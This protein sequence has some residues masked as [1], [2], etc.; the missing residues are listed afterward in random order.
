MGNIT[1]NPDSKPAQLCGFNKKIF[2]PTFPQIATILYSAVGAVFVYGII[3]ILVRRARSRALLVADSFAAYSVLLPSYVPILYLGVLSAIVQILV[4]IS[5]AL[6]CDSSYLG[7]RPNL[8]GFNVWNSI[9]Y[10]IYVFSYDVYA[11]IVVIYVSLNSVSKRSLFRAGILGL[12]IAGTSSLIS[13]LGVD[14]VSISPKL[15]RSFDFEMQIASSVLHVLLML[16]LFLRPGKR[17]RSA[18]LF[19]FHAVTWRLIQIGVFAWSLQRELDGKLTTNPPTWVLLLIGILRTSLLPIVVYL[20][21]LLDTLHWRGV[22]GRNKLSSVTFLA[23]PRYPTSDSATEN[24]QMLL[25]DAENLFIDHAFLKIDYL[26]LL[27][28]GASSSVFRGKL[29]ISKPGVAISVLYRQLISLLTCTSHCFTT[30]SSW[31]NNLWCCTG[32]NHN[33]NIQPSTN[34]SPRFVDVAVKM[35]TPPELDVD[36]VKS[37]AQETRA[38]SALSRLVIASYNP[39]DIESRDVQ[40]DEELVLLLNK[41]PCNLVR[42]YGLTVLPPHL[43]LVFDFCEGGSLQDWIES[44][45]KTADV[46]LRRRLC[47]AKDCALAVFFLHSRGFL[48][49]DI[50][51]ANFL[52]KG[53]RCLLTDFGTCIFQDDLERRSSMSVISSTTVG[54][55]DYMAPELLMSLENPIIETIP[56]RTSNSNSNSESSS[57]PPYQRIARYSPSSDVYALC[58]VLAG[59]LTLKKPFPKLRE[60]DIRRLVLQGVAPFELPLNVLGVTST[61]STVVEKLVLAICRGF[62]FNPQ[63]R[64]KVEEIVKILEME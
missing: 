28:R 30:T 8:W 16:I 32:E 24:L 56:N 2:T 26:N 37:F 55:I 7:A 61:E 29:T 36:T 58:V 17:R 13:A 57:L 27:G 48:H 62:A 52:L 15:N 3:L 19:I 21:L 41:R 47:L 51:T 38:W 44:G 25:D 39:E 35:Y 5:Y 23:L 9:L 20:T 18:R 64:P 22:L 50:K 42:F 45:Y 63:D 60:W 31:K 34:S 59:I 43:A 54:T 46:S 49:R 40:G 11:A 6:L 4:C 14:Y 1:Y 12:I 53:E 10:A 33:D